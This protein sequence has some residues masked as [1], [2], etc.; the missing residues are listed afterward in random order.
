MQAQRNDLYAQFSEICPFLLGTGNEDAWLTRRDQ[1][2]WARDL[3]DV[4]DA[5]ENG[6][7]SQVDPEALTRVANAVADDA[8][9][10]TEAL[11]EE[12]DECDER[13]LAAAEMVLDWV[14]V[15]EGSW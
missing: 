12:M 8:R 6:G 1:R 5:L 3:I 9:E 14:S 10:I 2:A 11:E 13:Q 15:S 7:L 4:L